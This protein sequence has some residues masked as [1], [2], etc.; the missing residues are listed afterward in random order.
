VLRLL[1]SEKYPIAAVIEYEYAGQTSA[2]EE[3]RKCKRF[4][5]QVL[6]F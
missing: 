4:I 2:I 6:D 3:V 1:R 5:E